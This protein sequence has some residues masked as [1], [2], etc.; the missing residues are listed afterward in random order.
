MHG[1]ATF[2]NI[3]VLGMFNLRKHFIHVFAAQMAKNNAFIITYYTICFPGSIPNTCTL[4][5]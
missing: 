3:I 1:K 5:E 2:I 4:N